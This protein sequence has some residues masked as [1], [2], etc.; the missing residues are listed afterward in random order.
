[1]FKPLTLTSL[2]FALSLLPN[3]AL[4]KEMR[5]SISELRMCIFDCNRDGGGIDPA[6]GASDAVTTTTRC[7]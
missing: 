7:F 5:M 4:T 6:N 1:M 3:S 2:V